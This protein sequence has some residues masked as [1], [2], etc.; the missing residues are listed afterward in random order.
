MDKLF[1]KIIFP[2]WVLLIVVNLIVPNQSFSES[3][4]RFL[5]EFPAFSFET[6]INGDFMRDIDS[7]VNDHFAGRDGF[8]TAQ[9]KMEYAIGKR[10]SNSVYVC[11]DRL[12][13]NLAMPDEDIVS[14]NIKGIQRFT[15]LYKLPSYL[16]LVPSAS[17][18]QYEKLP[19]FAE[20]KWDQKAL[21]DRVYGELEGQTISVPIYDALREHKDDYIYYRTDHHWTTQGA[22]LAYQQL[23]AAMNLPAV[24]S[25]SFPLTA[26]SDDF[27]GTL[28]SKSGVYDRM[29]DQ[30]SAYQ[31][32]RITGYT[33]NDGKTETEYPTVY[34]EEHLDKK[35]KYAYFL[36]QNQP[37]VT[38]H[39][40]SKSDKKLLLFKDSYSH[41]F[42]PFLANDYSEIVLVDMRYINVDIGKVVEVE[43]FDDALFLFSTDVFTQQGLLKKLQTAQAPK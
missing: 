40:D 29:P 26:V 36:G 11:K 6:L 14:G 37:I 10:E 28:S 31:T 8:I 12:M 2:L 38:I 3:E 30:I 20:Q 39:T 41:S 9:S 19:P 15:E 25:E 18:V 42:A 43:S 1:F 34:F 27:V 5:K 33:V 24:S 16:M 22:F 32:D 4:N 7:Y 17:A 21:I 23:A 35:D 13:S